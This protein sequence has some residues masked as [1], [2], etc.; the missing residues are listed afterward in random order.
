MTLT[1]A[2][3]VIINAAAYIAVDLAETEANNCWAVNAL[4]EANYG[5][6]P[7]DWKKGLSRVFSDIDF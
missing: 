5:I 7:P 1:V 4:P 3:G 6:T 2:L